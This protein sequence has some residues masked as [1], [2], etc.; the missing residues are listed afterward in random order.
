MIPTSDFESFVGWMALL[1]K[2]TLRCTGAMQFK[3]EV[4]IYSSSL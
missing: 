1:V 3:L 4:D 2:I